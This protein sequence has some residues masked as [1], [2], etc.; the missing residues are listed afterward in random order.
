MSPH[1]FW[2]RELPAARLT[3]Q[4]RDTRTP[5]ALA[6]A[7]NPGRTYGWT[8][9]GGGLD[10]ARGPHQHRDALVSNMLAENVE[11]VAIIESVGHVPPALQSHHCSDL[12]LT[13]WSL[14]LIDSIVPWR[15]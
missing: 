4:Q 7:L 13:Y 8:L 2:R 15:P 9:L 14:H 5:N 10:I 6:T 1:C 11:I 12:I 3:P